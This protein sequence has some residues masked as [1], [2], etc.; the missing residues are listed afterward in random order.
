LSEQQKLNLLSDVLGWHYPAGTE[1]VFHC[2]FCDH[3]K[4]KL[5]VNIEK[6]KYKCWICDTSGNDIRYLVRRF[7]ARNQLDQWDVLTNRVNLSGFDNLFEEEIEIVEETIKLPDE[8][9]SL[10]NRN[11]PYSALIPKQY[12]RGRG[13]TKEDILKWKIG[14]CPSGEYEGRIIIPSFN[15]D[16]YVNYFVGRSY[17]DKFPK[18]KNPPVSKNIVFN[19]LYIDWS[20]DI[21]LVEGIFDAIVAGD[22]AIPILGSTLREDGK[23]FQEAVKNDTVVYL[24]LDPDMEQKTRKLIQKLLS[25][26]IKVYKIDVSPYADVGEMTKEEF[27]KRK[28][29]AAFLNEEYYLLYEVI[30]S[31]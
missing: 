6:N 2:K 21:I 26:N 4:K 17:G 13:I 12:L 30:N 18:Y 23:L 27:E 31:L 1:Y 20:K 24:A 5:S 7:G 19:H 11:V 16:G 15:M 10:A 9:V 22:N 25:Y 29:G 28:D 3:H 8:F 14:Y